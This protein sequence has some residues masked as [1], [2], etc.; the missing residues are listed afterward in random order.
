MLVNIGSLA[1]TNIFLIILS[2]RAIIT[3]TCR[4]YKVITN[5]TDRTPVIMLVTLR[6]AILQ[7]ITIKNNTKPNY[8]E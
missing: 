3:R 2:H 5:I 8:F 6:Y 7:P 4:F 1:L